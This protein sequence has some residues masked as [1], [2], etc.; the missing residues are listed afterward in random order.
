MNAPLDTLATTLDRLSRRLNALEG[1][2]REAP[3]FDRTVRRE[4]TP[5][6]KFQAR[7]EAAGR[8]TEVVEHDRTGRP[9]SRF[10]GVPCW[11]QFK[12][13]PRV[14]TKLDPRG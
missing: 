7:E 8:L 12:Q 10:Y 5:E 13:A 11:D 3:P 2:Q 9:I 1:E 4:L 14:L 6:Q